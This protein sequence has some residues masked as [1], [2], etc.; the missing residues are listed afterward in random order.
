M[1]AAGIVGELE[2]EAAITRKLLERAPEDRFDWEPHEKSMTLGRLASHCVETLK[3]LNVIVNQDVFE[4]DP[5]SY[6]PFQAGSQSELLETFDANVESAKEVM[7]N[8]TDEK[9][10]ANWQMKTGGEVTLEM[11][12]IAVIHGFVLNHLVHHRGQLSVYLRW[13]DIPVPSIY[14]PSADEPG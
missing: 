5:N 4:M 7:H 3:W 6:T 10:L 13:N 12:R 9:L 14:G 8:Q 2:H 1:I 11:P